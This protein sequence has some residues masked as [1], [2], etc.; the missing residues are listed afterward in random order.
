VGKGRLADDCI[1][2]ACRFLYFLVARVEQAA[3]SP[4][5]TGDF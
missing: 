3:V 5:K 4:L 1:I 2:P